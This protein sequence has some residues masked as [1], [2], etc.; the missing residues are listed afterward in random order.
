MMGLPVMKDTI[1]PV[2]S[3]AKTMISLPK[4]VYLPIQPPSFFK[5]QGYQY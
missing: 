3:I 4:N 2:V 5:N 1:Y